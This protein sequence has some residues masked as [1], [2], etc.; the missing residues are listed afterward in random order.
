VRQARTAVGA[1]FTGQRRRYADGLRT[2]GFELFTGDGGFYP[3]GRLPG[4]LTAEGFNR[5]LVAHD[6]GIL[7]G[8][9]CDMARQGDSGP[10]GRFI[11]FSFGPLPPES[12]DND[13]SILA[14]CL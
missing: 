10:L 5:R 14:R 4:G 2:R 3:W 1:Y 13:M 6:A 12:Y 11:R 9:L 8:P 7:P